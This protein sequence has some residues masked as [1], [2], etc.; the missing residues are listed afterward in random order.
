MAKTL[1]VAD[2]GE[3]IHKA[4]HLPGEICDASAYERFFEDLCQLVTDNF[5]G[6]FVGL[7][8]SSQDDTLSGKFEVNECV[9]DDGGVYSRYDTGVVW[10]DGE[11]TVP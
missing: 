5:G 9:P 6:E 4:L 3:I 2:I 7:T 11:E 8:G 10:K 1:T